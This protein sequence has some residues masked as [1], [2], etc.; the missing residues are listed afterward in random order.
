MHHA[1][2]VVNEFRTI[3]QCGGSEVKNYINTAQF[4]ALI[5]RFGS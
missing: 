1:P 4:L 2:A 3:G 5:N